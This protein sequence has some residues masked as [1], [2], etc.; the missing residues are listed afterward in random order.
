MVGQGASNPHLAKGC[1]DSGCVYLENNAIGQMSILAQFPSNREC[2]TPHVCQLPR[3][4]HGC[5]SG[6]HSKGTLDLCECQ[7]F[8]TGFTDF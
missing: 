3:D 6:S 1:L 4:G 7:Y 8:Q 5:P 2:R